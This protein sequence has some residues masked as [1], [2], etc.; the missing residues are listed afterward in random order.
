[1]SNLYRISQSAHRPE[2]TVATSPD[3]DLEYAVSAKR[4]AALTTENLNVAKCRHAIAWVMAVLRSLGL[5]SAVCTK[6]RREVHPFR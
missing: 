4:V 6:D 2:R 1:M 5:A 3:T